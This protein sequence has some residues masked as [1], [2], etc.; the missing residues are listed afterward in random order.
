[1]HEGIKRYGEK[2]MQ[3]VLKEYAQLN[4]QKIFKPLFT[5]DLTSEQ[6]KEALMQLI[7]GPAQYL[8]VF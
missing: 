5:K 3:A 4:H 7:G 1:M 2:A 6:K 8:D